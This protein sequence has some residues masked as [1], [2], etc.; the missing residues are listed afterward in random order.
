MKIFNI[1]YNLGWIKLNDYFSTYGAGGLHEAAKTIFGGNLKDDYTSEE[2]NWAKQVPAFMEKF[3]DDNSDDFIKLNVEFLTP[4][5][6]GAK[7][8][9]RRVDMK[10]NKRNTFIS[11]QLLPLPIK[12]TIARRLEIED[13]LGGTTSAGGILHLGTEGEM[14]IDMKMKLLNKIITNYP[15]VEHFA[16]NKTSSYCENGHLTLANV[17]KCPYCNKPI[18]EKILT[19][20]PFCIAH[21]AVLKL[22][23]SIANS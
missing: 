3:S 1:F 11:N 19:Y 9:G 21:S 8:L 10:Y 2:L 16:F 17:D 15:N 20:N 14:P 6:S 23:A 5:E 4:L 18:V 12:T 22:A 13:I 7:R